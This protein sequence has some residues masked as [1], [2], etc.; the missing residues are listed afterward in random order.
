[1]LF[2]KFTVKKLAVLSAGSELSIY[3][4]NFRYMDNQSSNS[5]NRECRGGEWFVGCLGAGQ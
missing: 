2:K 4:L 5:T 3:S 1:M